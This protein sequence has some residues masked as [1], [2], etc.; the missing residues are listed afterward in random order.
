M[1]RPGRSTTYSSEASTAATAAAAE[2]GAT[3]HL[4]CGQRLQRA[5]FCEADKPGLKAP[6]A[7]PIVSLMI[8]FCAL[9]PANKPT[10]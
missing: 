6:S 3:A 4:L 2:A 8:H 1:R 5:A 7:D 9:C 10:I